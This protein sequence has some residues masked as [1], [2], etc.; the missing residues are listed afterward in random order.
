M[1]KLIVVAIC[2]VLGMFLVSSMAMAT[3]YSGKVTPGKGIKGTA[4]DLSL[5]G[6]LKAGRTDLYGSADINNAYLGAASKDLDRICIWCHTPHFSLK[7]NTV[8]AGGINYL[9]LWNHDITSQT[10]KPYTNGTDEPSDPNH[11]SEAERLASAP[12]G[13]SLLCLSCHDG[14]V[15]VNSYGR[16]PNKTG[17]GDDKSTGA[18]NEKIKADYKIGE[19]GDLSNH[20]PIGFNYD[21]VAA[22][23][24]EIQ[25]S[26]AA[27]TSDTAGTTIYA[28]SDLLWSGKM[29]CTTCHD[30]HNTKNTGEKFLWK[31]DVQSALCLTC[32][33]KADVK[34]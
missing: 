5:A 30:V 28:I 14:S 2:L 15:A 9:P 19:M 13:V 22:T 25:N 4:H 12:G 8:D 32:H 7:P 10:F 17:P 27:F 31:S 34:K 23:D 20:H 29:E 6:A 24:D 11:K 18:G 3:D 26:T 33:L 21:A 16:V 1:K